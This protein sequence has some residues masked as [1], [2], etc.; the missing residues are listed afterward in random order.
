MK[1][2]PILFSGEMVR[3]ILEGRKTQTRR[4]MKPQPYAIYELTTEGITTIHTDNE[5]IERCCFERNTHLAKRGLHGRKRWTDLLTDQVCG[6]WAEGLRGLVSVEGVQFREG[7]PLRI[8]VSRKREGHEISS[9]PSLHRFPWD[10]P[11]GSDAGKALGRRSAEQFSAQ[12]MLGD[13]KRELGRQRG[14]R[15]RI[16]R[17]KASRGET[18]RPTAFSAEVGD[19]RGLLQPTAC[20]P[21]SGNESVFGVADHRFQIE[22]YLWI[23]ETFAP[24][25]NDKGEGIVT[26]RAGGAHFMLCEDYGEGDPV[27]IGAATAPNSRYTPPKWKPSI[28]MPRWASRIA[29]EITSVRVERLQDISETDAKDEGLSCLTKDGGRTWK[30][31]IPDRDGLPGN[32]DDGWHWHEWE[33]DPR[34]AYKKLW[35]SINGAG[36]WAQNPWVW[37]IGFKRVKP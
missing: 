11:I 2:R 19:L 3:A 24:Y 29:L 4:I 15:A 18:D 35:E 21:L 34:L 16:E 22:Q 28:F 1:E 23:K 31:G 17:R 26:Y 9:P 27:A 5:T 14:S 32:D 25:G 8:L 20:G 30:F 12:P 36:S 10:A 33:V 37:V 13:A 6:L 7:L